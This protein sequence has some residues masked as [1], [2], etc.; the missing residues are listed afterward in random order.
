MMILARRIHWNDPRWCWWWWSKYYIVVFILFFYIYINT[1][2]F[3]RSWFS[4]CNWSIE[5]LSFHILIIVG[6]KKNLLNFRFNNGVFQLRKSAHI[7]MNWKNDWSY[8]LLVSIVHFYFIL[9]FLYC[10]FLDCQFILDTW[11][12]VCFLCLHLYVCVS[13][14]GQW[15]DNT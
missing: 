12:S 2:S 3:I 1:L 10:I 14:F 13:G 4:K 6:Q 7:T 15:Q 11:A 9:V 8:I 5:K